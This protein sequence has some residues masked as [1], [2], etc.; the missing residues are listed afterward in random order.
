MPAG[1]LDSCFTQKPG[2][3]NEMKV[4]VLQS[5]LLQSHSNLAV[6]KEHRY[7]LNLTSNGRYVI[8]DRDVTAVVIK[9]FVCK[10]S[11]H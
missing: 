8:R 9:H 2:L 10:T 11:N 3:G 5:H 6:V 4:K 7:L 1:T